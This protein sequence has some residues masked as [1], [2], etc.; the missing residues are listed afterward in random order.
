MLNYYT[1]DD[2]KQFGRKA[3]YLVICFIFFADG[4]KDWLGT[5]GAAYHWHR[6][7]VPAGTRLLAVINPVHFS[8]IFRSTIILLPPRF[9]IF[10]RIYPDVVVKND[11]KNEIS[12][13]FPYCSWSGHYFIDNG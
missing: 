2:G 12:L 11:R 1:K 5:F 8:L 13:F 10:K 7:F 4:G 3:N 9:E 6:Y